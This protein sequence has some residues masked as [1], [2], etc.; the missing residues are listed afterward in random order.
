MIVSNG[1]VLRDAVDEALFIFEV[2]VLSAV[3]FRIESV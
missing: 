3:K 2:E 1:R